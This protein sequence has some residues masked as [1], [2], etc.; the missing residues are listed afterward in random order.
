M[1]A[2]EEP[3]RRREPQRDDDQS[4]HRYRRFD[5][6]GVPSD[7]PRH[8]ARHHR[9]RAPDGERAG[10]AGEVAHEPRQ[11]ISVAQHP[12]G[13]QGDPTDWVTR[14]ADDAGLVTMAL[15]D[16]DFDRAAEILGISGSACAT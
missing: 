9:G 5:Q 1:P 8:D 6:V 4:K 12:P 7:G 2:A 16:I 3:G 11:L 15:D 10:P 14:A 13:A